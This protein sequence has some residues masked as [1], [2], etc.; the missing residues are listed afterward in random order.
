MQSADVVP[1]RSCLRARL[2]A[3]ASRCSSLELNCPVTIESASSQN[4]RTSS[5]VPRSIFLSVHAVTNTVVAE[6]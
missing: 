4:V 2:F 3:S 6:T 1:R 5:V